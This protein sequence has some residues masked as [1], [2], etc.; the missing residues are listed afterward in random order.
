[1]TETA[2]YVPRRSH[3]V[4]LFQIGNGVSC[5]LDVESR[6]A[7]RA[8]ENGHDDEDGYED[9]DVGDGQTSK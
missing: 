5:V 2:R 1:M 6:D 8:E 7:V 9:G 4:Y 3:G